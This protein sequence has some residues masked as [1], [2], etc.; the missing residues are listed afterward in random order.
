MEGVY[1]YLQ[2]MGYDHPLHPPVVHMPT[3]L[4]IGAFLFILA[5]IILRRPD[6]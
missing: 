3:G 5:A 4:V 1:K 6:M 2:G